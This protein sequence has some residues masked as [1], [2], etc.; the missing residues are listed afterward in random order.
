MNGQ[1]NV[2]AAKML[3]N[4]F[5]HNSAFPGHLGDWHDVDLGNVSSSSP[6]D[7]LSLPKLLVYA[8]DALTAATVG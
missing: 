3:T 8:E 2:P 1:I 6:P 4:A 7:A 5:V